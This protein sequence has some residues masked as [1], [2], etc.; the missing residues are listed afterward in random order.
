M[1]GA[2]LGAGPPGDARGATA[3]VAFPADAA[4]SKKKAEA[5]RE[6]VQRR[7]AA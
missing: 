6:L 3:T 4:F 1:L 2:L 7:C 5:N